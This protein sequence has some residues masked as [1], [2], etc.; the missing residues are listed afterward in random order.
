MQHVIQKA[1][2]R[3]M[4]QS[5]ILFW[6]RDEK[7][8]SLGYQS[9]YNGSIGLSIMMACFINKLIINCYQKEAGKSY[10]C[11]KTLL[12]SQTATAT[13]S[14]KREKSEPPVRILSI[15]LIGAQP[16]KGFE[17]RKCQSGSAV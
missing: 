15:S 6:S 11:C 13:E 4:V 16:S 17:M 10:H 3:Y 12:S 7:H 14:E 9:D 5:S 8:L 2:S 1:V